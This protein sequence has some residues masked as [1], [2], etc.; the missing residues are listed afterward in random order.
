MCTIRTRADQ[1][2]EV[3]VN[4]SPRAG[5]LCPQL[6]D[7][8]EQLEGPHDVV[9]LGREEEKREWL[10]SSEAPP[11]LRSSGE[12]TSSMGFLCTKNSARE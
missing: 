1:G 12:P 2:V 10:G 8:L 6:Y 3:V 7:I 4:K 11:S 9:I 5:W